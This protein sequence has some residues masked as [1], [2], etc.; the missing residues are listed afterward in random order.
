MNQYL[1]R[2]NIDLQ[3]DIDSTKRYD[4]NS[5]FNTRDYRSPHKQVVSYKTQNKRSKSRQRYDADDVDES[6]I[7]E[8]LE[9]QNMNGAQ[10]HDDIVDISNQPISKP[11]SNHN[12][13]TK[14][15]T[16][17]LN[18]TPISGNAQRYNNQNNRSQNMQTNE[19]ENYNGLHLDTQFET[20]KSRVNLKKLMNAKSQ[21]NLK[22]LKTKTSPT[23]EYE[24]SKRKID[25]KQRS[26]LNELYQLRKNMLKSTDRLFKSKGKVSPPKSIKNMRSNSP[27][28]KFG[29]PGMMLS[30]NPMDLYRLKKLREHQNRKRSNEH[31]NVDSNG[32][33]TKEFDTQK[34]ERNLPRETIGRDQILPAQ[35]TK[36]GIKSYKPLKDKFDSKNSLKRLNQRAN[37]RSPK[38][39]APESNRKLPFEQTMDYHSLIQS[40]SYAFLSPDHISNSKQN[41]KQQD[42]SRL[43]SRKGSDKPESN[44]STKQATIFEKLYNEKDSKKLKQEA[45][46]EEYIQKHKVNNSRQ[47]RSKSRSKS[48]S[49]INENTVTPD[50]FYEKQMKLKIDSE[51][52][53]VQM[54]F[55]KTKNYETEIKNANRSRS[56]KKSR[57]RKR[58]EV[59][60]DRIENV[61]ERLFNDVRE[62]S[63]K[64]L[65]IDNEGHHYESQ[66][67]VS[68]STLSKGDLHP[69]QK[70]K[71]MPTKGQSNDSIPNI[72]K[73]SRKIV[74]PR[75]DQGD[76][77]NDALYKDA[78]VRREKQKSE[79]KKSQSKEKEELN[80]T[81][82][83]L[84]KNSTK[85]LIK[86]YLKEFDEIS[87]KLGVGEEPESQIHYTQFLILMQKL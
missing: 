30:E 37:F 25:S 86:K 34:N 81:K 42:K 39:K 35:V 87:Q 38:N 73:K 78:E 64:R 15:K 23:R 50:T 40:Q 18:Y 54:M 29:E 53:L 71:G 82:K 24:K 57:S 36:N 59:D 12:K 16:E 2:R 13:I 6:I 43:R 49:V 5:D 66:G 31:S 79:R 58:S 19:S 28:S 55:E 70:A 84:L 48:K 69:N 10:N 76:T 8:E 32:F 44:T 7:D 67:N 63:R 80:K 77:V 74:T 17:K 9:T 75:R 65:G 3:K 47:R 20:D 33:Q 51:K 45:L 27:P 46:K 52:K 56:R 21:S 62:R 14:K 83:G 61:H 68:L 60:S 26:P 4:P 72:S 41:K 1:E 11:F 22:Q 85:I